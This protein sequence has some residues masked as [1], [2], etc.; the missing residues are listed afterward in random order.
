WRVFGGGSTSAWSMVT[1]SGKSSARN[2]ASPVPSV[3]RLRRQQACGW[4][5]KAPGR[6]MASGPSPARAFPDAQTTVPVSPTSKAVSGCLRGFSRRD[7]AHPEI[8]LEVACGNL[9]CLH[10]SR[11]QVFGIFAGLADIEQGDLAARLEDAHHL[12]YGL[13]ATLARSDV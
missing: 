11:A 4:R 7:D 10:A 12:P 6:R 13:V 3:P 5:A 2:S 8:H 9:H 1:A